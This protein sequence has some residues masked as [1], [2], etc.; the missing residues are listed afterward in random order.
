MAINFNISKVYGIG[1]TSS[2]PMTA[3][4]ENSRSVE[5]TTD[6]SDT[7][8]P[9]YVILNL[10][11]TF[12]SS[13]FEIL[14]EDGKITREISLEPCTFNIIPVTTYGCV[15]KDGKVNFRLTGVSGEIE[16]SMAIKIGAFTHISVINR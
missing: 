4:N 15:T 7:K 3:V 9:I 1:N 5:F 14:S 10:S 12:I 11:T 16:T 2:L 13:N 8:D 6:V